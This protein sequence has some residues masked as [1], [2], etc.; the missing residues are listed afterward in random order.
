MHH[1][2]PEL[3]NLKQDWHQHKIELLCGSDRGLKD[4]LGTSGYVIYY[5][6]ESTP[7]VQGSAAELQ[8]TNLPSGTRQELL[9]QL[10]IEYWV[11]HLIKTMGESAYK[12]QLNLVTDSQ[13]SI[14][15]MAKLSDV[16]SMKDLLGPDIDVAIY[17]SNLQSVG[18]FLMNSGASTPV[19][20]GKCKQ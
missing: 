12:I 5:N 4:D 20:P 7:I 16:I 17:R 10:C 13:A 2:G 19:V 15:I 9:G 6:Q 11:Q 3:H 18:G 1:C 14:Q 8:T